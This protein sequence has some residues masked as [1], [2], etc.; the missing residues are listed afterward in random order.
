MMNKVILIGNLTKDPE[1]RYT[2]NGTAVCTFTLAVNRP[3]TNQQGEREADFINIQVWRAL[4]EACASHLAKGRKVGVCGRLQT[5][6]YE[7]SEGKK[8]YVTEVVAEEVEFLSP[9]QNQSSGGYNQDPF[10]GETIDI[11]DDDLPF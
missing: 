10:A 4:A 9:T 5:R 7:N 11:S 8:V 3:F 1:L 2:N 6:N